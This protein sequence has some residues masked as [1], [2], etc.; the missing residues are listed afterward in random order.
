[1]VPVFQKDDSYRGSAKKKM[2][3]WIEI[4][5]GLELLINIYTVL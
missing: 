3:R 1:M 5:N 2:L 4:S